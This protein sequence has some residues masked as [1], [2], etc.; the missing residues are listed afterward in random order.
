MSAPATRLSPTQARILESCARG[1][2]D[3]E[4]ADALG[5]KFHTAREHWRR[6]FKRLH[7]R[8]RCEAITVWSHTIH[9]APVAKKG[10]TTNPRPSAKLNL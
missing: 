2:R 9:P 5:M 10:D 7:V 6:I 8:S 3:K 1:F 4:I